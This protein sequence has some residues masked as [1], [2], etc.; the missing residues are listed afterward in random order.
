MCYQIDYSTNLI[1][2]MP[3]Y[4]LKKVGTMLMNQDDG[5]SKIGLFSMNYRKANWLKSLLGAMY[6]V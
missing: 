6:E 1:L 5:A 2:R 4:Y 3:H